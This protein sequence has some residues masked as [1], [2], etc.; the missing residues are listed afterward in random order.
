[1]NEI[2]NDLCDAKTFDLRGF[3]MD[4]LMHG[5]ES[6]VAEFEWA[7]FK[8]FYDITDEDFNMAVLCDHFQHSRISDLLGKDFDDGNSIVVF[9]R[10][11]GAETYELDKALCLP[12][13]QLDPPLLFNV[14]NLKQVP[15]RARVPLFQDHY[16]SRL[17]HHY[18]T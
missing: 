18:G 1:M 9:A 12:I 11:L 16:L 17:F 3:E 10:Q 14:D 2:I 5:D 6:S 15:L 8:Y 4:K 7:L 13:E